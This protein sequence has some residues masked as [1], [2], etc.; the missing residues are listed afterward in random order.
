VAAGRARSPGDGWGPWTQVPDWDFWENQGCGLAV[1]PLGPA[2]E[3]HL[4]VLA[5]DDPGR[6]ERRV[7]ARA[8]RDDDLEMAP[9]MG[10]WRP[11]GGRVRD[12]RR[13]RALLHT[14]RVLF[15][16]GSS[17]D[18]DR[19]NAH[20]FGTTVWRYPG[21]DQEQPDTPSTCSASGTRSCPTGGCSRPAARSSTT[22][23]SA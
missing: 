6:A 13:A 8:R 23:S 18:P 10:V 21:A 5:V 2:A 3:P 22:R 17:N 7:P 11:A 20:Q 12:P 15:F 1:T 16:A 14:G 9:Q 19:H 4:V